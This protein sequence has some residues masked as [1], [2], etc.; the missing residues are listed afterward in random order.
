MVEFALAIRREDGE[1]R[2]IETGQVNEAAL[3]RLI[4]AVSAFRQV[5]PELNLVVNDHLVSQVRIT[6][7]GV[8]LRGE[9]LEV[10]S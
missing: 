3:W 7:Q 8:Q 4:W 2:P 10:G 9:A 1:L 5:M 6:R